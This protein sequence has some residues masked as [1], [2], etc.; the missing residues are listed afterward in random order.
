MPETSKARAMVLERPGSR[1]ILKEASVP[2]PGPGQVPLKVHA[3]GICRTLSLGSR[4]AF[5]G[6]S[7]VARGSEVDGARLLSPQTIDL[8]F[9]E[10]ENGED[11]VRGKPL[12]FGSDYGLP[13][14]QTLPCIPDGRFC[15][16]VA[17]ADR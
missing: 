12:R 6:S 17:G 9:A 16:W 15:F 4:P 8:I 3:C 11:L 13:S 10:H 2:A 14:R 1:L 5:R 7:V